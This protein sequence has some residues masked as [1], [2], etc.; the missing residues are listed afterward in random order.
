MPAFA[1]R[2]VKDLYPVFWAKSC[3]MILGMDKA[4]AEQS[5][6]ADGGAGGHGV[7]EVSDWASRTTLD[8]IGKAGLDQ[9]FD[10]IQSPG[11]N[12]NQTVRGPASLSTPIPSRLPLTLT[13]HRHH[14]TKRSSARHAWRASSAC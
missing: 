11:N 14:S 6:S 13:H 3:E 4:L 9:S 7:V 1:F 5:A 2:H 8:I 12:L 10:A